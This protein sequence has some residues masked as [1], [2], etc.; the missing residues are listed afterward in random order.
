MFTRKQISVGNLLLNKNNYR[1]VAQESQK[2]ARDAIIA[3]QG[4]KLVVL[5]KDIVANGL[6][7]FDLPMVIS[8]EDG[9]DNYVMMEGN[10]RLTAIQLMLDPEL[11][12]GTDLHAAFVKLNKDSA[13]AIPKVLDCTIA[14]NRDEALLWGNRKHASGLEG[15]GTEPWTAMAKARADKEQGYPTPALDVVNYVLT[16]P[17]LDPELRHHLEGSQ[18]KLTT[19]ERLVTTKELQ[20]AGK[21]SINDGEVHSSYEKD[22]VQ[23]FLTDVVEII[24][25]GQ[26]SGKKWTE[27]DIDSS[28]KRE[29]FTRDIVAGR[30]KAKKTA[31]WHVSGT[32]K[33]FPVSAKPKKP[34]STPSTEEQE[35]LIPKAFKLSLPSGKINDIFIE[36]KKLDVVGCRHAVSVLFRVFFEFTLD[37]FI[38]KRGITLP[39]KDGKDVD[40]LTVRMHHV[41][42]EVKASGLLNDKELKPINTALSDNDSL[43]APETLNAYVHSKWMNPDPLRLKLTW[44]NIEHFVERLWTSGKK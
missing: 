10:R 29:D 18:F 27:R 30:P 12:K 32:P 5:A 43:L 9:N 28:E 14:S 38:K 31:K 19:L 42:K 8:A 34:K 3:E 1:I 4:R 44:S 24:A 15:A 40:K 26:K 6:S 7:P 36:L 23:S 11:C 35:N 39:Q 17:A 21:L 33:T 20:E 13:D 22:W 25:T 2:G 37:D 16:N 41:L